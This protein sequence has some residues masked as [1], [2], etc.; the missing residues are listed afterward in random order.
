MPVNRNFLRSDGV[1]L[2]YDSVEWAEHSQSILSEHGLVH[3][4][5]GRAIRYYVNAVAAPEDG[6]DGVINSSSG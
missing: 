1:V 3:P 2:M 5:H 4:A 6:N